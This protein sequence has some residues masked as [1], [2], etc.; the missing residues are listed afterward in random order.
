VWLSLFFLVLNFVLLAIVRKH[1]QN[2]RSLDALEQNKRKDQEADA[3]LMELG[4]TEKA[5]AVSGSS[6]AT[7]T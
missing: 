4:D 6:T 7:T 2:Q 1:R 3:K 5:I